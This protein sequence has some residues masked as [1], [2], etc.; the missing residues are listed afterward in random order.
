MCESWICKTHG[1]VANTLL[2]LK[3]C[4]YLGLK[5]LEK[6]FLMLALYQS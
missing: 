2:W 1:S 5:S 4:V 6:K 3:V